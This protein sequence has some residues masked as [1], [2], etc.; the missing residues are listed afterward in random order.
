MKLSEVDLEILR[1]LKETFTRNGVRPLESDDYFRIWVVRITFYVFLF[2]L[3]ASGV[4]AIFGD[5]A[6]G[7]MSGVLSLAATF[8]FGVLFLHLNNESKHPSLIL[9]GL[10]WLSMVIAFNAL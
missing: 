10:T 5:A 4:Y 2:T 7:I 6:D 9:F 1:I 8:F 3:A